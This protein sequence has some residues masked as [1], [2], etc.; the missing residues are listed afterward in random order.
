M[1][2][3]NVIY[4]MQKLIA[5][6]IESFVNENLSI[7]PAVVILG[8]R[9]CGKS[10]LVKMLYQHSEAYLYLDLQ[11]MDDLNK[12]REPMLFLMQ[13]KMLRFALMKFS[14]CLNFF[15]YCVVP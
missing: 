5:R 2:I 10:T 8:P 14:R 1:Q 12:L 6:N 13:I 11:N 15:P 9:Q 7:F 4:N 3:R